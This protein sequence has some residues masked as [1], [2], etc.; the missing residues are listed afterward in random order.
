MT[1]TKIFIAAALCGL[2]A[3]FCGVAQAQDAKLYSTPETVKQL[4]WIADK[5]PQWA[6][7]DVLVAAPDDINLT[8]AEKNRLMFAAHAAKHSEIVGQYLMAEIFD[9]HLDRLIDS[10]PALK[11]G[12]IT[13]QIPA[14]AR[15]DIAY[16]GGLGL[17]GTRGIATGGAESHNFC[18]IVLPVY[19]APDAY[20]LVS[21]MTAIP[22]EELAHIPGTAQDWMALI[23][24]HETQHCHH[25]AHNAD[26]SPLDINQQIADETMAD[27]ASFK[28]YF[29]ALAARK[30][31]SPDVPAAFSAVRALRALADRDRSHATHINLNPA[32]GGDHPIGR[33]ENAVTGQELTAIYQK[34]DERIARDL[35]LSI[36]DAREAAMF[37]PKTLYRTVAALNRENVFADSPAAQAFISY[38]LISARIHAPEYFGVDRP[39]VSAPIP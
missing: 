24:A 15:E 38:F 26:G 22:A 1:K 8:D 25:E 37:R 19:D 33:W 3:V 21:T 2:S 6:G 30:V 36:A 7:M 27:Q 20:E 29:H 4:G 16:F 23:I 5:I 31:T 12:S 10:F 9:P 18:V 35:N 14:A 28:H 17:G 34:I 11:D 32:S 39:P 13:A